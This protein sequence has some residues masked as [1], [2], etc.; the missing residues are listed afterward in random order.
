MQRCNTCA[1]KNGLSSHNISATEICILMKFLQIIY[2]RLSY[3]FLDYDGHFL[4][5]KLRD[6]DFSL[7]K[8]VI[9]ELDEMVG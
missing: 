7:L 3:I 5:C 1:E 6:H 2:A 9:Q 4:F 8:C